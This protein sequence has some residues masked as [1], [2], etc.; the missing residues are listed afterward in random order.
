MRNV[1]DDTEVRRIPLL[2]DDERKRVAARLDDL[3]SEWER[4]SDH[5]FTLRAAAYLDVCGDGGSLERYRSLMGFD[6]TWE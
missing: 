2:D 6:L 3:C 1:T 5:F 4:R